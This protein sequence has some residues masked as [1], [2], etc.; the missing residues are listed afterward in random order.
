MVVSMLPTDSVGQR[1]EVDPDIQRLADVPDHISKGLPFNQI[2]DLLPSVS[3][4]SRKRQKSTVRFCLKI[5]IDRTRD[6]YWITEQNGLVSVIHTQV[7]DPPFTAHRCWNSVITCAARSTTTNWIMALLHLTSNDAFHPCGSCPRLPV[8]PRTT[9]SRV[10][11]D[12]DNDGVRRP[13]HQNHSLFSRSIK[14]ACQSR[15]CHAE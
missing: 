1:C 3:P 13:S 6:I 9:V 4:N 10:F 15:W 8:R 12:S 7:D 5:R 11:H 2:D 14:G